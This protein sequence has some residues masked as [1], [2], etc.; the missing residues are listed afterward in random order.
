MVLIFWG[1][2][3]I[4]AIQIAFCISASPLVIHHH[5]HHHHHYHHNHHVLIS[6]YAKGT[7][8]HCLREEEL[9]FSN[10]HSNIKQKAFF[11]DDFLYNHIIIIERLGTKWLIAMGSTIPAFPWNKEDKNCSSGSILRFQNFINSGLTF[12]KF[13]QNLFTF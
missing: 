11:I 8:L 9:R 3:C 6:G 10:Q 7:K 5:H 13:D 12:L 4:C 2:I 1:Q